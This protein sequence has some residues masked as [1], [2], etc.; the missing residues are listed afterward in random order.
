[1]GELDTILHACL[2]LLHTNYFYTTVRLRLEFDRKKK[3][4]SS[5]K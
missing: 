1:M 4:S 5:Y 3:G 2:S